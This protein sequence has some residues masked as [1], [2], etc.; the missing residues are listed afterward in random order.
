MRF[1][2]FRIILHQLTSKK[3]L[4]YSEALGTL[5]TSLHNSRTRY[6]YESNNILILL[7]KNIYSI[8]I[9]MLVRSE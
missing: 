6:K 1:L 9:V 8:N 4:S 5:Y 2:S 3:N 7:L